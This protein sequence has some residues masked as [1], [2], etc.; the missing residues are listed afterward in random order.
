M[1]ECAKVANGLYR[2]LSSKSLQITTIF[3]AT[4]TDLQ[5]EIAALKAELKEA[6]DCIDKYLHTSMPIPLIDKINI[7]IRFNETNKTGPQN[8]QNKV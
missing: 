3:M 8:A 1:Q 7:I 2:V 6:N 5:N 4:I